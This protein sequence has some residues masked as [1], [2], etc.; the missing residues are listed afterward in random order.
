MLVYKNHVKDYV[1][2][3]LFSWHGFV[4][5]GSDPA[6]VLFLVLGRFT[7]LCW[8]A[9]QITSRDVSDGQYPSH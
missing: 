4:T 6:W 8:S 7:H 2:I 1:P 5:G 3:Q 9:Q